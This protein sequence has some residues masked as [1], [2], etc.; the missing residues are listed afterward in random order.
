MFIARARLGKGSCVANGI[1]LLP[2]PTPSH[3]YH[4]DKLLHAKRNRSPAL[5]VQLRSELAQFQ[6]QDPPN[7]IAE[8]TLNDAILPAR[9]T[10][11]FTHAPCVIDG[12]VKNV[13]RRNGVVAQV[14]QNM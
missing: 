9:A 2:T 8:T 13:R 10:K 14:V 3:E 4:L 6:C 5:P 11:E 12:L 1:K 7:H